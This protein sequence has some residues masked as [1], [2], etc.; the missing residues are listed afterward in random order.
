[1][2]KIFI[3]LMAVISLNSVAQEGVTYDLIKVFNGEIDTIDSPD[4][5]VYDTT[6]EYVRS[7][8]DRAYSDNIYWGKDTIGN[9]EELLF[10]E[11]AGFEINKARY[12]DTTTVNEGLKSCYW[13]TRYNE[14]D[15]VVTM[16]SVRKCRNETDRDKKYGW[17]TMV[18]PEGVTFE[19]AINPMKMQHDILDW[20]AKYAGK[21]IDELDTYKK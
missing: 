9:H 8:Y 5:V 2:K 10:I 21:T 18:L 11:D 15:S 7:Y 20:Y 3:I 12:G 6:F 13:A 14:I 16:I 4:G 1:M 19:Q 17:A